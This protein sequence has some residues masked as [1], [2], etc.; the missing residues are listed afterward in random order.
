LPAAPAPTSKALEEIYYTRPEDIVRAVV[1][2][3]QPGGSRLR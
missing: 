3:M 1:K 2:L